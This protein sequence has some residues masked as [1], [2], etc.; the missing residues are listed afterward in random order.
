M[1]YL[2][3]KITNTVNSR[4]YIGA[5]QT[6][7]KEDGYMGSGVA[8]TRA[9]KKYGKEKFVKEIIAECDS[10]S[11]MYSLE[12]KLVVPYVKDN[13]SYN[14]MEGGVGGFTHINESGLNGVTRRTELMENP[15]WYNDWKEKQLAGSEKYTR[16]VTKEE[17]TRRGI[18]ANE[19][20]LRNNGVY[21]FQGQSHK[22]ETKTAIGAKN[23]IH[24]S[25]EGNSQYGSIWITDGVTSKKINKDSIMPNGWNRGR[26][27]KW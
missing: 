3:Y 14:I 24:Q 2:I 1:F 19:T 15:E 26:I 5:H 18:K 9:Y 7:N 8:I 10:E 22:D 12:K 11:D 25:G 23:S 4:Y 16:S 20:A 17:Y 21:G 6:T 27:K 13:K